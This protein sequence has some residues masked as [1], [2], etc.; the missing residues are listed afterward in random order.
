MFKFQERL[1][2][3]IIERDQ[4]KLILTL[5]KTFFAKKSI[6]HSV[7]FVN[8]KLNQLLFSVKKS[9]KNKIRVRGGSLVF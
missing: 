3:Q 9:D 4:T 6:F 5:V 7:G 1:H 2:H 8:Q